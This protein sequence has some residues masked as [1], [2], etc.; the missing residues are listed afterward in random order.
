[1]IPWIRRMLGL[2]EHSW[3]DHQII[4]IR[5]SASQAY[6]DYRLMRQRCEKCGEYRRVDY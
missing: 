5:P 1:M 3:I 6:P 4:E 2:C